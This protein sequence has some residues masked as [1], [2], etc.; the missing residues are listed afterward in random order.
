MVGGMNGLQCKEQAGLSM[1]E[2]MVAL[3]IASILTFGVAQ[4]FLSSNQAYRLNEGLSR[5]QENVRFSIDHLQYTLRMA[6]FTGCSDNIF[7]WIDDYGDL[8][9]GIVDGPAVV[10][11]EASGTGIGDEVTPSLQTGGNWTSGSGDSMPGSVE[12]NAL[13]GTDVVLVN[14][15][16][17]LDVTLTG[18]P[19][20]SGTTVVTDGSN[21]IPQGAMVMAVT[22]D[23]GGGD[24]WRKSSADGNASI[25][26]GSNFNIVQPGG[27]TQ[28]YDNQAAIYGWTSTAFYIGMGAGGEPALFQKRL[29]PGANTDAQELVEG[30]ESMQILYGVDTSNDRRVNEYETAADVNDW[31]SVVSVRLSLLLRTPEEVNSD[32]DDRIYNL[33]GTVVEPANDRRI[34][35]VA[36]TTISLRNRTE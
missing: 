8:D 23:C 36:T 12:E 22:A 6:G 13:A 21:P 27:F 4:I 26:K 32:E 9:P 31:D 3:T 5:V 7:N 25:T 18:N 30:I 1:V 11:W 33:A 29:D 15:A 16:V 19:H 28:T 34:R 2:L 14:R 20:G 24:L 10:G 17:T 35:Q